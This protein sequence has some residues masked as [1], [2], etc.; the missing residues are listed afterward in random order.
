[1][2]YVILGAGGVGSYYGARLID[3]GYD[4]LFIARGEHLRALKE[5]GLV[6][7]NAVYTFNKK[8][9]AL[10]LEELSINELEA[11]DAIILATKSTTTED[12]SKQL[13]EKYSTCKSKP[14]IISIQNGVENEEILSH[15][16]P[17]EKIIGG[18]TRKIGA[19][20]IEPGVVEVAGVAVE[21][22]VGSWD[23]SSVNTDFLSTL[24][25]EIN[26][27]EGISCIVAKDIQLELWKKLIIN[28]GVN[29]ICALLHVKTGVVMHEEKLSKIVYGLMNETAIAGKAVGVK[30]STEDVNAM[31]TLISNFDSIK[32]S[33]LVDREHKRPMEIDEICGIVIRYCEKIGLDAPYTRTVSSL[34]EFVYKNECKKER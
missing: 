1:M 27:A 24:S 31:F 22:I 8:V 26:K 15:Y 6:L 19:H 18:L 14:Y 9:S 16:F 21:T 12:I 25:I 3:A 11:T 13:L 30:I 29:A 20:I 7:S 5:K 33:M 4:V 34:L 23:K 28:N 2:K 32:P 10:S 17:K